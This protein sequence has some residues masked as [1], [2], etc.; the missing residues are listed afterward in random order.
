MEAHSCNVPTPHTTLAILSVWYN[1][2]WSV[3]AALASS[4][5]MQRVNYAVPE[6]TN[7]SAIVRYGAAKIIVDFFE[8]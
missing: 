1:H 2:A 4:Y 3:M 7:A 8:G 6:C 5:C